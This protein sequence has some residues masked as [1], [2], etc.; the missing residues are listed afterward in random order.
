MFW[1]LTASLILA[2]ISVESRGPHHPRGE[3]IV[4]RHVHY[5]P[6]KDNT[7]KLTEDKQLLHDTQHIQEHLEEVIS[8]QDLSKMTDEELE[9]YYFQVHDTDKNSKL[10]GLELLQAIL[11]TDPDYEQQGED[12]TSSLLKESSDFNYFVELVDQ[13][14]N[15]DDTDHDGYLSY[16]EYAAK[17]RLHNKKKTI[18]H[19]NG[20]N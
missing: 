13:V 7:E 20:N 12:D 3:K 4:K 9:F 15:E 10:D 5:S 17:R 6:S 8:E 11:H 1:K 2:V 19:Y 18:Q 14:L 16:S